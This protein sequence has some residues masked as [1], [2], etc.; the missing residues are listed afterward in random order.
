[1][2]RSNSSGQHQMGDHDEGSVLEKELFWLDG[3][4]MP[5]WGVSLCNAQCIHSL[6]AIRHPLDKERFLFVDKERFLFVEK[7]CPW[8][9]LCREEGGPPDFAVH[10]IKDRLSSPDK[11]QVSPKCSCLWK[12]F[13]FHKAV[14]LEDAIILGHECVSRSDS[15]DVVYCVETLQRESMRSMLP[16]STITLNLLHGQCKDLL[17]AANYIHN[18]FWH[19]AVCKSSFLSDDVIISTRQKP[20]NLHL[21]NGLNSHSD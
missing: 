19:K 16:T 1:V 21:L 20:N 9:R 15:V 10:C 17:L 8:I 7:P 12:W 2:T 13:Q 3:Q 11:A 6:W 18:S 14:F 5:S 4:V